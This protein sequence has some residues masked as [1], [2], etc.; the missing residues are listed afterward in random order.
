MLTLPFRLV[1]RDPK[2][3]QRGIIEAPFTRD[4]NAVSLIVRTE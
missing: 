1:K 3:G 4:Y 2:G